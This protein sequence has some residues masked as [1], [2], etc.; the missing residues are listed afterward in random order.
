MTKKINVFIGDILKQEFLEPLNMSAYKLA[1]EIGVSSSL[2]SQLLKGKVSLSPDM[3]YKLGLLF[4]TGTQYWLDMQTLCDVQA[5]EEK[6]RKQPIKIK[7]IDY[8]NY[9]IA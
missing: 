1:K 2:I 4:G 6:Y 9:I 7:T 3:A 8:K 5:I